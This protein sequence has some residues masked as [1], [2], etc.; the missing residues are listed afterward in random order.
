MDLNINLSPEDINREI[1]SQIAKS[2][3]G[4][5]LKKAIERAVNEVQKTYYNP[6][7][8]LIRSYIDAEMRRIVE[9]EFKD[10]IRDFI[11]KKLSGDGVLEKV[12]SDLFKGYEKMK[13]RY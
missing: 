9:T 5:E 2:A 3:L 1:A 4:D 8:N 7:D 6:F 11:V 12:I 13:D 10:H